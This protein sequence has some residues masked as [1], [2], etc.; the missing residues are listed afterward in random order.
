MVSYNIV[1][2]K[3]DA[4]GQMSR[5]KR[6]GVA[7]LPQHVVQR[8]NN[9]QAC[10]FQDADYLFYLEC[11]NDASEKHGCEIHAYVL[12]TNHVHVLVTPG[13][14]EGI[15]RMM[16]SVGRRYVQYINWL[17]KRTGTLWEGR[18]KASLIE[19]DR[20]FLSCCRYIE[21]NPVRAGIVTSPGEYRWS[22]YRHHAADH[23]DRLIKD[24]PAYL[25]LGNERDRRASAYRDLFKEK[26]K[27]RDV[28]DIRQSIQKDLVLGGGRFQEEIEQVLQRRVRPGEKGRPRR[29]ACQ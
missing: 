27:G 29:E 4:E 5:R 12:M 16:Q 2:L 3:C 17:Y 8:G 23:E 26:I 24:H 9:L 19:S 22:S 1:C 14:P 6:Y 20:Y 28:K 21:E 13:V 7:G 10:F 11:L 25:S 15:S 18:Y